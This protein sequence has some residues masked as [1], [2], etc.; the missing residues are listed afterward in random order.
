VSPSFGALVISLDFEIH[1][2][3]R[4]LVP[5]TG[6]YE[7]NLRGVREAVPRMLDLFREFDVAAT[8][9]T[10]GFLFARSRAEARAFEPAVKPQYLDPILSAYQ[11]TLGDSEADDPFHFAPSL[12]D[13]I[14]DT[15]RQEIATHTFSHY[16]CLEPGQDRE[17][18]RAD[19]QS[20]LAIARS[21]GFEIRSIVF[22]GNQHNPA[23]DDV[24]ADLG[25]ACYRG[26]QTLWMYS[27]SRLVGQTYW[28]RAAR[29]LDGFLNV[30]GDHTVAWTDVSGPGRLRN[31]Q[32]SFFLRPTRPSGWRQP[33]RRL[34]FHRIAPSIRRAA[35]DKRLVHLWWHPHNFGRHVD[36]NIAQ[37][38]D[39]LEVYAECRQRHGMRSL[40]M[41]EAAACARGEMD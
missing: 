5:P 11:E 9:A 20:A 4:E 18:F 1:W 24:V 32:A 41:A 2:G 28:K 22:P 39:L 15:P 36:A 10:V 16:Y 33:L 3:V 14:R 40:T 27:T 13:R 30:G 26:T 6:R 17:S 31:V 35:R 8:W 29:L 19:L 12:V 38:R 25:I 37:L 7:P 23:Y 34:Q 21:R